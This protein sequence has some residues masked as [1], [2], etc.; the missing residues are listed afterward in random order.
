MT[1]FA[2]EKYKLIHLTC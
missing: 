2:S 1:F